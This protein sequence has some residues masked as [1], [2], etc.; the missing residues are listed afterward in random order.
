MTAHLRQLVR[1]IL[2]TGY[3]MSLA[4]VDA[5]GPWVADVIYVYDQDYRLYWLSHLD[6]RHSQAIRANGAVAASI[7]LSNVAGKPNIGLQLAGTAQELA[8]DNLDWAT[9]H[10]QKRRKAT[11]PYQLGDIIKPKHAWYGLAPDYFDVIYEP[12]FGLVK[13]RLEIKNELA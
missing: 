1:H 11:R 5:A 8:G 3:L 10:L 13:Q 9:Q 2:E 6:T 12:E 4:T 7:T